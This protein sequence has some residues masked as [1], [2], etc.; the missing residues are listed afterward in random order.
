MTS[1]TRP[2]RAESRCCLCRGIWATSSRCDG[3]AVQW[4]PRLERGVVQAENASRNYGRLFS[5]P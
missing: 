4:V 1:A 5:Y 3:S 2:N